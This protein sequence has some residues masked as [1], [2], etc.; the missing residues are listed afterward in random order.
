[1][2][3]EI[4]VYDNTITAREYV[5]YIAEQAGAFATIGRDKK[6]YIKIIGEDR[7]NIE[8]RLF[9]DFKWKEQFKISRIAYEDGIQDFKIGNEIGN[10]IWINSNNMYIIN[11]AQIQNIYDIYK[12]F[13]IYGF[14]GTSI[15]DPALDFG[16]IIV[17]E[18]KP[19][20]YQ[21]ELRY[22]GKFIADIKSKIQIKAQEETTTRNPSQKTINRRVQSQIDQENLRITQLAQETKEHEEKITRVEQ[23]VDS[24]KQSVSNTIDYK[25]QVKGATE[26]HLTD[27]GKAEALKIEVEANKTYI[28]NLFPSENLYPSESLFPNMENL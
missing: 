16:D 22:A 2:N 24:I 26:I 1:M 15:I 5:S 20:I 7:V 27:S 3:Q 28:N 4:A 19:A 12:D 10:T 25:R 14:E 9:R 21:G 18:G 11:K 8:K 13:E 6:L 23:D 17:I